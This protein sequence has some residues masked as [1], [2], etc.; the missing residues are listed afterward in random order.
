MSYKEAFRSFRALVSV[1]YVPRVLVFVGVLL[2]VLPV[3]SQQWIQLLP[4][5]GPPAARDFHSQV[6]DPFTNRMIVFGGRSVAGGSCV[7]LNDTWVLTNANGLG[8]TSTWTQLN[9]GSVLPVRATHSA[10]YDSGT[11]RMIV[12]GGTADSICV[13]V[14]T[15]A[16]DVWVLSNANGSEAAVPTWMQLVTAGGP[17]PARWLHTTSYDATTNRLILFGGGVVGGGAFN[18]VWVLSHANGLGGTPTWMQLFPAGTPPPIRENHTAVF[19]SA[20]NR[21]VVFAGDGN[22]TTVVFGD[23]WVLEHANGLGGTPTWTQLTPPGPLP[24]PRSGPSAIYDST[25]NRMTVFGGVG[26]AFV[27]GFFAND[28][29]VLANAN[30]LGGTP[31][32]TQL[33]FTG[34]PAPN[35]GQHEATFDVASNRMTVFG[36]SDAGGVLNDT[37][38]LTAANGIPVLTVRIDIKPGSSPNSINLGSAGTIP[39]AIL[40]TPDFDAP[41]E[42]DPDSLRLAGAAVNLIGKSRRFQCSSQD[43]NGDGLPDLVCHFDTAQFFIEVG[44]SVA[45]LEG[46]TLSGQPIRGEDSVRIVPD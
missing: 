22:P 29:W 15:L 41:A 13:G 39:V 19:D 35:R 7:T 1:R 25:T 32:W 10:A 26:G 9:P 42:V 11:N 24:A 6:Y 23:V 28:V 12:F 3:T 38:I 45:V 40:S 5:G 36:G 43:V 20:T 30:G 37:W 4:S 44:E 16:N 2:L 33:T 18:D 46:Q 27:P 31:T 8:G 14:Q 21:L 34:T 17:P